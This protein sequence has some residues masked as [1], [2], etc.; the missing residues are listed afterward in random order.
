[1]TQKNDEII[2]NLAEANKCYLR[3]CSENEKLAK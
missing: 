1:M 3:Q 2:T